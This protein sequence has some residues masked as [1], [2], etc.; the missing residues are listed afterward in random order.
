MPTRDDD[1]GA[2]ELPDTASPVVVWQDG[3]CRPA[4]DLAGTAIFPGA[5]NPIHDGHRQL[6]E[7]AAAFL[8][9][10]VCFELSIRNVDKPLLPRDE[11]LRRLTQIS[12]GPVL[13][14]SAA[15]F[16]E[17]AELFP[18]AWFV[19]GFDTAVRILDVRYYRHDVG[20]RDSCLQRLQ[21]AGVR[22]LVAG[23]VQSAAIA[24]AF[25]TG[26]HLEVDASFREMFVELPEERFRVDISSTVLRNRSQLPFDSAE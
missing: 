14:T 25:R 4:D 15:M 3:A 23:R 10:P 22:F 26:R 5:F 24:G 12:E 20:Q 19:V 7:A 8:G 18:G 16:A 6:R 13:L 17:K 2:L 11:V 1:P 9:C 21:A